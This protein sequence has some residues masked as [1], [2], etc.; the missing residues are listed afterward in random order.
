MCFWL[1]DDRGGGA[2]GVGDDGGAR[3]F[4]IFGDVDCLAVARVF[5]GVEIFPDEFGTAIDLARLGA[6]RVWP[7][8]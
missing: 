5:D 3:A 4:D 6:R 2:D 8:V 1:C 7:G